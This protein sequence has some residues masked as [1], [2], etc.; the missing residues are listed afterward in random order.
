MEEPGFQ[1]KY[2]CWTRGIWEKGRIGH[3]CGRIWNDGEAGRAGAVRGTAP[4]VDWP[5]PEAGKEEVLLRYLVAQTGC[6]VHERCWHSAALRLVCPIPRSG[7][8]ERD[9]EVAVR[10][11]Q[12]PEH[13]IEVQ[14]ERR[15]SAGMLADARP[16]VPGRCLRWPR[17][18]GRFGAAA[19]SL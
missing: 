9:P 5:E 6:P 3:P 4:G 12:G 2:A 15:R 10:L 13:P 18:P 7:L 16:A 17:L 1:Y 8:A 19:A 14:A 11:V